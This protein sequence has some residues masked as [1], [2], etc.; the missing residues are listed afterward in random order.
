MNVFC[1]S[2]AFF[3]LKGVKY[4]ITTNSEYIPEMPTTSEHDVYLRKDLRYGDDD[5]SRW[6]Q[7]YSDRYCHL[8]G[9]RRHD[10]L[11]DILKWD[12]APDA[13][14]KDSSTLIEGL[15][16]LSSARCSALRL[17]VDQTSDNY[18]SY[19]ATL[20]GK[21]APAA[22]EQLVV[23]A[24]LALERLQYIPSTQEQMFLAVCN[25]QRTLL[26]VDALLSY[27]RVFKPRMEKPGHYAP[28]GG[29]YV[30]AYT[31]DPAVAQKLSLGGLAILV[32]PRGHRR[33]GQSNHRYHPV[34]PRSVST[35][36]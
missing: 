15:G 23:S 34:P 17:L 19:V 3:E 29:K 6:P 14:I 11:P 36:A 20:A 1:G 2:G 10:E 16:K 25:L 5:F 33:V 18:K 22:L 26:E 30:G 4:V 7:Q 21:T 32:H 27:M 13:F 35:P 8:A 28:R 31:G 24:T 12:P 9:I